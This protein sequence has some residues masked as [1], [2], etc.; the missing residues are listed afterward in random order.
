MITDFVDTLGTA[1]TAHRLRRAS[2]LI[3]EGTGPFVR[4]HGITAPPR[5]VSM[6]LLLDIDGSCSITEIAHRLRLSHPFIVKLTDTL[7]AQ[8]LVRE[9]RDGKD[10]RRRLVRLTSKGHEE[11][12]RLR[13]LL[14]SIDRVLTEIF[15]EIGTDIHEAIGKLE[16]ALE[17]RP[18]LTRL[19][20]QVTA[21]EAK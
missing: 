15:D 10:Q 12:A 6:L 21:E 18:L 9:E 16:R 1:F 4:A 2:E 14:E 17:E 20:Q 5:A 8:R 19:E 7:V 13:T 11:V 3:L